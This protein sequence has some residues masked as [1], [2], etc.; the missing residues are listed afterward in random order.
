MECCLLIMST[1]ADNGPFSMAGKSK[2][3][4]DPLFQ[5]FEHYLMNRSYDDSGKFT[6]E[7]AEEY[8]GYLDSTLAHVPFHTRAN[9]LEDLE[10]EAHEMLVKKMYGCVVS[11]EYENYGRVLRP[12]TLQEWTTFDYDPPVA[13]EDES[14]KKE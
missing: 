2:K 11:S 5:L 9:V 14:T 10:A 6:K 13:T 4:I 1:E 3:H 7:V 12:K 8:M